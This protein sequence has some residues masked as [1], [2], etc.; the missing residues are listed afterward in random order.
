MPGVAPAQLLGSMLT[1]F[2][3]SSLPMVAVAA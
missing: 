3:I 1:V 2:V